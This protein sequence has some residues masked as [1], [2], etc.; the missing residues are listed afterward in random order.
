VTLPRHCIMCWSLRTYFYECR[1]IMIILYEMK[2]SIQSFISPTNGQLFCFKILKFTLKYTINAPTCFILTK[3]SSGTLQSV[4]RWSH[5]IILSDDG[6]VKPKHVGAF[7][8]YFNVN[9]NILKLINCTL[10]GLIKY[11][12][13]SKCTVQLWG[14]EFDVDLWIMLGDISRNLLVAWNL[15]RLLESTGKTFHLVNRNE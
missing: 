3:P 1:L 9:F 6:L 11:W 15:S 10:V 2:N 7:I 13:T 14:G 5:N 4:L 12:I 8:V